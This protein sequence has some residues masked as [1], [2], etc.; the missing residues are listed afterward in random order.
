M[1]QA[2]K[3]VEYTKKNLIKIS[4]LEIERWKNHIPIYLL[5]EGK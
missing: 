2:A 1:V 3:V 5:K 4:S